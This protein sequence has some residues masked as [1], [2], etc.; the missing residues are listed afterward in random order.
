M[1]LSCAK[2]SGTL[3]TQIVHAT[4]TQLVNCIST[5]AD[6]SFVASLYKCFSDALRVTGGPGSLP[7]EFHHGIT[8][9][10]KRQLQTIAEKRRRRSQRPRAEIEDEKEDLALYEEMEEFALEDMEKTLK[11][12][13]SSHPLL[14]AVSSVRDLGLGL[15]NYEDEE[16]GEAI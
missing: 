2:N 13:D 9:A 12:F 14:V 16:D 3:T 4:F 10:S 1:L 7:D 6:A 5:E 8:E 15:S 11:Y